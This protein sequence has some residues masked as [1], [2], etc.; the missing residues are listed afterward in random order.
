MTDRQEL[1]D[2]K[3]RARCDLFSLKYDASNVVRMLNEQIAGFQP[4]DKK[5]TDDERVWYV[6]ELNNAIIRANKLKPELI[7]E[8]KTPEQFEELLRDMRH[9]ANVLERD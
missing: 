6:S 7:Q 1:K 5:L 3:R 9:Y 2:E 4:S 8:K